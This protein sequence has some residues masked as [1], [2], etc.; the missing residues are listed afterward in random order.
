MNLLYH[1]VGFIIVWANICIAFIAACWAIA[2]ASMLSFNRWR[3]LEA[4]REQ[5]S[6]QEEQVQLDSFEM[7]PERF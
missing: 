1:W 6:R 4:L 3:S 5:H 2:T 7:A